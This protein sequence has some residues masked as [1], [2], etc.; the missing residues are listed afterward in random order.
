MSSPKN[1]PTSAT[2]KYQLMHIQ[3]YQRLTFFDLF[4]NRVQQTEVEYSDWDQR[5]EHSVVKAD[6]IQQQKFTI[7][8]PKGL[9]LVT[10]TAKFGH[11]P[12]RHEW[13]R[14]V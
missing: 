14:D 5:I 10:F 11:G 12:W 3:P 13:Q 9:I 4:V 8:S 2:S 1:K 6:I 7:C